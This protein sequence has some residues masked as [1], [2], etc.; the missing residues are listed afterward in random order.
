MVG[1]LVHQT[2]II[3]QY[4]RDFAIIR[5]SELYWLPNLSQHKLSHHLSNKIKSNELLISIQIFF[6]WGGWLLRSIPT[7]IVNQK[8]HKSSCN[9]LNWIESNTLSAKY[10]RLS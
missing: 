1:L 6:F 10:G 9:I 3:L 2:K 8:A 7:K 5:F 4:L